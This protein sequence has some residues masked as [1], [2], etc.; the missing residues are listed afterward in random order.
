MLGPRRIATAWRVVPALAAAAALAACGQTP[1]P[2]AP[3]PAV[4][5]APA[6]IVTGGMKTE[7]TI[8]F[9]DSDVFDLNFA[10][11]LQQQTDEVHVDFAGPTSLNAFPARM[12]IWL[13]E[14]KHSNGDVSV[15]DPKVTDGTAKT[16]GIFGVGII[17]DIID[18]INTMHERKEAAAR[19]AQAHDYDARILY[20]STTGVAREVVFTRR[21]PP[22]PPPA[23]TPAAAPAPGAPA[24]APA[25]PATSAPALAPAGTTGT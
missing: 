23:V 10:K 5:I 12:N 20:D 11:M 13:S 24:P 14:V 25:A 21:P 2:A 16:R 9:Y 4:G 15:E 3:G 22:P 19:L 7:Q 6:T 17:F 18:T 8:V 1:P